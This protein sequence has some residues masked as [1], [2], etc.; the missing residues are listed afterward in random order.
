MFTPIHTALG[1]LLLYQGAS[2]LLEHNGRV[3]GI[4]SILSTCLGQPGLDNL[5]IILGLAF[6]VLPISLLAPSLLPSFPPAPSNWQTALAT[7]GTGLLV[8]WGTKV[9]KL[10]P[11]GLQCV[12]RLTM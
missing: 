2:G 4:S 5:P 3:F 9:S 6:S 7:L 11:S 12:M 8:G 1:S 10:L